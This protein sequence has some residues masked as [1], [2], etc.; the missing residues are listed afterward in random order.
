MACSYGPNIA[1]SSTGP[2][3]WRTRRVGPGRGRELQARGQ[4]R[5]SL[6]QL[7]RQPERS[8]VGRALQRDRPQPEQRQVVKMRRIRRGARRERVLVGRVAGMRRNRGSRMT[9]PRPTRTCLGSLLSLTPRRYAPLYE[10]RSAV[11]LCVS[12]Y[13]PMFSVSKHDSCTALSFLN[14]LFV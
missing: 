5:W 1:S 4:Q 13:L 10:Y 11:S 3:R 14:A 12:I 7:G 8:L 9:R 6:P 2:P